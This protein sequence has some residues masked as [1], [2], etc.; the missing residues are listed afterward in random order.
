MHETLRD[1][2]DTNFPTLTATSYYTPDKPT[3]CISKGAKHVHIRRSKVDA[4]KAM[5]N[6]TVIIGIAKRGSCYF[7][8][9]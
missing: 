4:V 8:R 2:A 1:I 5:F 6:S 7:S 9:I 3:Y